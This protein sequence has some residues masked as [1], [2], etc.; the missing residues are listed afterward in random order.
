MTIGKTLLIL[1]AERRYNSIVKVLL[2]HGVKKNAQDM[3][4]ITVL[5]HAVKK[6]YSPVVDGL[7]T[8]GADLNPK[9]NENATRLLWA[10]CPKQGTCGKTA[11]RA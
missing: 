1:A 10:S 7:L 5:A 11:S 6:S 8:N 9:D 2:S 4:G 3:T